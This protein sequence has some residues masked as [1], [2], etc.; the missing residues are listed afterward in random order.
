MK[1][2]IYNI[3]VAFL[4]VT[5]CS[6][7]ELEDIVSADIAPLEVNYQS[8][9]LY[10][11][12]TI[13]IKTNKPIRDVTFSS[14]DNYYATVDR[15]G[16]VTAQRVGKTRI[17]VANREEYIDIPIE[18]K[19]T[20]DIFPVMELFLGANTEVL[21]PIFGNCEKVFHEDGFDVYA[22][23]NRT[24]YYVNFFFAVVSDGDNL[25]IDEVM[26]SIPTDYSKQVIKHMCDRYYC[27]NML[28]DVFYF[29]N[30]D[31]NVE[32]ELSVSNGYITIFYH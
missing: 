24:K 15:N 25:I 32:I 27:Y 20:Y 4:M 7:D 11:N 31:D 2:L 22:Y 17:R 18:V 12:D 23:Y 10:A 16:L 1:Q 28:N 3:I 21:S 30:H 9:S 5:I 13:S 8:L 6:C 29:T 19:S 26:L 14:L